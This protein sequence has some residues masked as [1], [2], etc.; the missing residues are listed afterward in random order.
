M[1]LVKKTITA[2]SWTLGGRQLQQLATLVITAILAKLLSPEDFGLMGMVTVLSGMAMILS[3]TG[4]SA[5]VIQRKDLSQ[6]HY[7]TLFW[8]NMGISVLVAGA[9]F[10]AA[11]AIA[12]F[13][14]RPELVAI[15]QALSCTFVLSALNT[16]PQAL[17]RKKMR[18]KRLTIMDT[19]V[20]L[21]TGLVVVTL[22]LMG[23]G[24][25]ALVAQPIIQQSF[26]AVALWNNCPWRPEWR[27]SLAALKDVF[28]FSINILGIQYLQYFMHNLD[29]LLVGRFLGAEA[30]GYYTLA[31]KLMFVPIRNICQEIVKVLFP[32][33]SQ[34]QDDAVA[35]TRGIIRALRSTCFIVFPMLMGMYMV[36]D[37][38]IL[39]IFGET[40][41][42]TIEVLKV[43]CLVGL[44]QSVITVLSVVFKSLGRP[45]VE[46]KVNIVRLIVMS[47]VLYTAID[48]GLVAFTW[49]LFFVT[50][51]FLAVYLKSVSVLLGTQ[52]ATLLKALLPSLVISSL[53]ALA[54]WWLRGVLNAGAYTGLSE[55]LV[56]VLV[57]AVLYALGLGA[58][59]LHYRR[60][61]QSL[62]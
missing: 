61:N 17:M 20:H 40:W 62:V 4:F 37:A 24:V 22:A 16:I 18:F 15:S 60:L 36:A 33:L 13:Y 46:L 23:Y 47:M 30:L 14:H 45:E 3:D 26:K 2:V 57:G 42:K 31:Y 10:L 59:W 44:V 54:L 55:L 50:A 9:F 35:L 56:L 32:A 5:A 51:L 6:I 25:W 21:A 43:L 34:L 1:S 58:L 8:V 7:S 41:F 27:F 48:W 19:G 28:S 11:P 49:A 38:F 29:Y 53:M 52:P 39:S 12:D